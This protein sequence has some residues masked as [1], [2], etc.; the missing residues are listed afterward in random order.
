MTGSI[1][2]NDPPGTRISVVIPV[3]DHTAELRRVLADLAA[4]TRRPDEVVV[5][6]N[7]LDDEV[8]AI[9]SA[10]GCVVVRESEPGVAAAA[11]A[12][13]DAAS[14]DIIAR[15]DADSRLPRGWIAE[16]ERAMS[17]ADLAAVTGPGYFYDIPVPLSAWRIPLSELYMGL[18]RWTMTAALAGTPVFGSS[19]ALRRTA[20]ER[21]RAEVHRVGTDIH[22][23][24]DVSVHLGAHGLRVGWDPR[25]VVGISADP[26]RHSGGRRFRRGWR[27]LTVHWPDE[28]PTLRWRRRI[29]RRIGAGV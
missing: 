3:K 9:A 10:A 11:S 24:V 8:V 6:D 20:W 22:D 1:G 12:G 27:A 21:V 13:Y 5:V 17:D 7:G 18:Y 25:L 23:D 19:C 14:G 29:H 4:Q 26:L 15:C 28:Q 16:I 2:P